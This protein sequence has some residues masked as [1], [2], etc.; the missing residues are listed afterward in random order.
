MRKLLILITVSILMLSSAFVSAKSLSSVGLSDINQFMIDYGELVQWREYLIKYDRYSS[1]GHSNAVVNVVNKK[2]NIK[3]QYREYFDDKLI[4]LRASVGGFS[5]GP[6]FKMRMTQTES[7]KRGA[8][9]HFPENFY[10]ITLPNLFSKN[11]TK[12]NSAVIRVNGQ[13][14]QAEGILARFKAKYG[15]FIN[16]ILTQ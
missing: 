4:P 7:A 12:V 3:R 1:I 14:K 6:T 15:P 5:D 2:N 9:I 16:N 8:N 10:L 13:L 11:I